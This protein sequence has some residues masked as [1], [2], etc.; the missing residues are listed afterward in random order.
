MAMSAAAVNDVVAWV[1]LA[2]AIAVSGSGK[3]PL[4]AL[5]VLLSGCGFVILAIL[6]VRPIFKWMA[7]RCHEGEP[8]QETYVCGTL[9]AVLAAGF[10]TDA[11]GIHAM[12]GAFVIGVVIPKEGPLA[13]ALVEKVEDLVSACFGKIVGTFLVSLLCKLPVRESLALGFLMNTKGLVEL[14][15]LNIGKDRKVSII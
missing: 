3:S 12:F 7:R 11:I 6:I 13:G 4:I 15:V 2:L 9:A 10:V 8:V 1:L 5:W 14:I